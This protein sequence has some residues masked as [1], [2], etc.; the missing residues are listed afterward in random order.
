MKNN[1]HRDYDI[2]RVVNFKDEFAEKLKAEV[3]DLKLYQAELE[4]QLAG[5]VAQEKPTGTDVAKITGLL[6]R[7]PIG[8]IVVSDFERI[9][10]I[11][12]HAKRFLFLTLEPALNRS[13]FSLFK[14]KAQGMQMVRWITQRNESLAMTL[15]HG[16]KTRRLRFEKAEISPREFVIIIHDDTERLAQLQSHKV[17]LQKTKERQIALQNYLLQLT[18]SVTSALK[19]QRFQGARDEP[20]LMVLVEHLL[21]TERY[22]EL[23][24]SNLVMRGT[25]L[26]F[27]EMVETVCAQYT[28]PHKHVSIDAKFSSFD[29]VHADAS[30]LDSL[31]QNL[32]LFVQVRATSDA[33]HVVVSDIIDARQRALDVELSVSF[34]GS[35]LTEEQLAQLIDPIFADHPTA[36]TDLHL[37]IVDKALQYY[38]GALQAVQSAPGINCLT[39]TLT[40]PLALCRQTLQP[41][42]LSSIP[43]L[44]NKSIVIVDDNPVVAEFME[45]IIAPT[46]AN[47]EKFTCP[48]KALESIE[49][50]TPDIILTDI[51]ME[52][53]DGVSLLNRVRQLGIDKPVIAVTAI[54]SEQRLAEL[55]NAGFTAVLTKPTSSAVIYETLVAN[56]A[57]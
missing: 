21:D 36:D 15:S 55:D 38:G 22:L 12:S 48:L 56:C 31:L 52:G 10:Q 28:L 45:R 32:I 34:A 23:S 19:Y 4:A 53:I 42:D 11:N 41:N 29:Y 46:Q 57:G 20:Q 25:D 14:D 7:L 30:I 47:I 49:A 18:Q 37:A 2:E 27:V 51:I 16:D 40:L 13:L 3:R 44:S 54:R 39:V 50:C 43:M 1:D 6:D 8:Y 9:T 33:V 26:V 5:L 24:S 35:A 17:A